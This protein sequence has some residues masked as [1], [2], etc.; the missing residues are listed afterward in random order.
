MPNQP[1]FAGLVV[2]EDGHPAE[3]S[4][5]G[6]EP[7]YVVNDA[8]FRRHVPAEQIDRAVL[9]QMAEMMKGSED[10]LSEQTAKMLGQEDPFSKAIIEQQLKNIDKQFDTLMQAGIPE[11]MRTYLGMMG[12][13]V[14]I[15]YHGELV[16]VEQPGS[17]GD[18]E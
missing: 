7:C 2:D 8:G 11:D 3:S 4:F 17:A 1:L 6:S 10:I 5:I 15:N 9:A 12:F 16:R 14:V 13:K 18:G